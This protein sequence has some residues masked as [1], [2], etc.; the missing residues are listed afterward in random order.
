M[1]LLLWIIWAYLEKFHNLFL[2][3][4]IVNDDHLRF[5]SNKL[6]SL[7]VFI[8]FNI[9]SSIKYNQL[10]LLILIYHNPASIKLA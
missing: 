2:N 1:S 8:L 4:K 9:F 7:T 5:K 6:M 10:K 3:Y